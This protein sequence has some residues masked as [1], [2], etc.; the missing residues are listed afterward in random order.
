MHRSA[1][2]LLLP[3]PRLSALLL[4]LVNRS[5]L[6]VI[7]FSSSISPPDR[8][9]NTINSFPIF[10][11]AADFFPKKNYFNSKILICR[12]LKDKIYK[13]S[14]FMF[15]KWLILYKNKTMYILLLNGLFMPKFYAQYLIILV[16]ISER[17]E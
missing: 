3:A 10:K 9:N 16:V 7:L 14:H 6:P 17:L 5:L 15:M 8:L 12:Q 2:L 1:Y 13:I 11:L 4:H